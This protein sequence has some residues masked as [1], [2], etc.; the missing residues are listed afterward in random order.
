MNYVVDASV[1]LKWFLPEDSD[2][3]EA[4]LIKFLSGKVNLYAPDLLL[5]EAGSALWR[6]CV[7]RDELTSAEVRSIYRDLLTLPLNFQPSERVSAAAFSLAL[8]H[9]HSVYDSVYCALAL[10]MDCEFITADQALVTKLSRALPFV[11]HVS[12]LNL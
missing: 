11:R 2:A 8:T 12:G 3:A 10:E 1:A 5:V 9:R 7:V 4:L 6:R